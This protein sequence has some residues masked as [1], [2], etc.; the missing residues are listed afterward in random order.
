MNKIGLI[1]ELLVPIVFVYTWIKSEYKHLKSPKAS[2]S[3][4][5]MFL[6]YGFRLLGIMS[7]VRLI[8]LIISL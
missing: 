5:Q 7:I 6:H 1:C 8:F 2:F 4:E 3:R